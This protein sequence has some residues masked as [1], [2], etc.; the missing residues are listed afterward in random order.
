MSIFTAITAYNNVRLSTHVIKN[1]DKFLYLGSLITWNYDINKEVT[2]R[3]GKAQGVM[4]MFNVVWKST[5]ISI[6][7]KLT[8]LQTCVFI[9]LYACKTWK[10]KRNEIWQVYSF[11]MRCYSKLLNVKW[12]QKVPS[13]EVR[14]KVE[15]Q[16]NLVLQIIRRKL[17][18][19]G[20]VYQMKDNRLVKNVVV[21]M[22]EGLNKR[23]RP[24][25]EWLDDI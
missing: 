3:I 21:G 19:F 16:D 13:K 2:N 9:L 22:M 17:G 15:V 1:I 25:R 20:H 24:E 6:G 10:F 23:G 5:D 18:L 11:E 4:A 8:I 12:D 14:N 7:K